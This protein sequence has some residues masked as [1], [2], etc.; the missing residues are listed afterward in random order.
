MA[1]L[2]LPPTA[3]HYKRTVVKAI[4]L[5]FNA[6]ELSDACGWLR[7]CNAACDRKFPVNTFLRLFGI[8]MKW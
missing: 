3:S 7:L 8:Q 5:Y 4:A 1:W 6:I 2:R